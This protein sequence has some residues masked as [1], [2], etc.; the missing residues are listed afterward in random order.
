MELVQKFLPSFP[1]GNAGY[2]WSI[3]W[4]FCLS[5]P[6]T[7]SQAP[8]NCSLFITTK[9][10]LT[11]KYNQMPRAFALSVA[12]SKILT[13]RPS[14]NRRFSR[15]SDEKRNECIKE[16]RIWPTVMVAQMLQSW[17]YL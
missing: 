9:K 13:M 5:L 2:C 6:F 7:S 16:D 8:L 12:S 15:I 14:L 3:C 1:S 17:Q 4:D 10:T 11:P